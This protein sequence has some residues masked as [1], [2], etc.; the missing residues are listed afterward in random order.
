MELR[1]RLGARL[2]TERI[3]VKDWNE[4]EAARAAKVA[5]KTIRRIERGLNYEIESLEK[6]CA[7]LGRSYSEWLIDIFQFTSE[8]QRSAADTRSATGAAGPR[9]HKPHR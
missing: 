2:L 3:Q 7:A 1:R 8:T 9:F 5:P 4:S 6:Y